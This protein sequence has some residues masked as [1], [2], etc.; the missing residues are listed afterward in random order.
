[1]EGGKAKYS[2]LWRVI[3][4]CHLVEG[5]P[6]GTQARGR[7]YQLQVPFFWSSKIPSS[8]PLEGAEWV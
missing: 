6:L 3:Y 2:R 8:R 7:G 1:M 5:E 4:I